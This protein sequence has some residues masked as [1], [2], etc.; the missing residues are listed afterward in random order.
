MKYE[1][2]QALAKDLRALRWAGYE[3]VPPSAFRLFVAIYTLYRETGRGLTV[4]AIGRRLG[5]TP[6]LVARE[7]PALRRIG[8]VNKLPFRHSKASIV[9]LGRLEMLGAKVAGDNGAG[10]TDASARM[11][12]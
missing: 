7:L 1:R 12:E 2:N 5:R 9:P 6:A 8:L 11:P 10:S 4:R 3:V